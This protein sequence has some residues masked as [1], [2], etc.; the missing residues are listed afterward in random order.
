LTVDL[1]WTDMT[2]AHTPLALAKT[3]GYFEDNGLDVKFEYAKDSSNAVNL[4]AAAGDSPEIGWADTSVAAQSINQ[5]RDL[6]VVGVM[7][8][9][10]PIG[11]VSSKDA[12]VSSIDDLPGKQIAAASRPLPAFLTKAALKNAGVDPPTLKLVNMTGASMMPSFLAGKVD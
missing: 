8:R 3:N 9:K 5:G 10:S 6:E 2:E 4:V 1:A 11:I 7:F 12:G